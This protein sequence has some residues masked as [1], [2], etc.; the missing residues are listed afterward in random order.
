MFYKTKDQEDYST[1][2]KD[3]GGSAALVPSNQEISDVFTKGDEAISGLLAKILEEI[4][5][6][7]TNNTYGGS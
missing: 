2:A 3:K 4:S 5:S 6:T 1:A 7:N